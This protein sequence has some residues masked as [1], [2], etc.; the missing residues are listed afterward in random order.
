MNMNTFF[1]FILYSML[2]N[3]IY[4][5]YDKITNRDI[6]SNIPLS[7]AFYASNLLYSS[8]YAK[9]NNNTFVKPQR[10]LHT[11]SIIDFNKPMVNITDLK[12]RKL[13]NIIMF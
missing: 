3:S 2:A 9:L 10:I 5:S 7:Q 1:L 4:S 6:T 13:N 8:E 11:R 12:L